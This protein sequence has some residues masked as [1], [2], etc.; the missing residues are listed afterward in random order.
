VDE[1]ALGAA[2]AKMGIDYPDDP[3]RAKKHVRGMLRTC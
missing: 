1:T 3:G 2:L